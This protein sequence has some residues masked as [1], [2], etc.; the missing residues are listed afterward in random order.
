MDL[1][2]S[3]FN[4][5][6]QAK[7]VPGVGEIPHWHREWKSTFK[8]N[9]VHCRARYQEGEHSGEYCQ[10]KKFPGSQYC[11]MHAD[12]KWHFCSA[13]T[14]AGHQCRKRPFKNWLCVMHWSQAKQDY[15][16]EQVV[17]IK[18]MLATKT[19]PMKG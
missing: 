15:N 5:A 12:V 1:Q 18:A 19:D 17:S 11:R 16:L 10:N 14:V 8:H 9:K 7:R 6:N 3:M 2:Q 4:L 13:T